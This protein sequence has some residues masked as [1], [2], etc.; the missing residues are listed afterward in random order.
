MKKL[1]EEILDTGNDD[2]DFSDIVKEMKSA[3]DVGHWPSVLSRA[4]DNYA[5]EARKHP[6]ENP[7]HLEAVRELQKR[8]HEYAV[9]GS[10]LRNILE[11]LGAYKTNVEKFGG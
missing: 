1:F 6:N 5:Y 9:G 8:W 3:L 10:N 11:K 2:M 4:L 7:K